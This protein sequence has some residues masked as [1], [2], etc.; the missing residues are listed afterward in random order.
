[1]AFDV[2]VVRNTDCIAHYEVLLLLVNVCTCGILRVELLASLSF[3]I[4]PEIVRIIQ[5]EKDCLL[6]ITSS[7]RVERFVKA[8]IEH[9]PLVLIS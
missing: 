2:E 6:E 9:R 3:N 1:M 4:L 5:V 8:A 7:F